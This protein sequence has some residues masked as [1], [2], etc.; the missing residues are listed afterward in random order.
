MKL[1][2]LRHGE[3]EGNITGIMQGN[4]ETEL[5]ETGI[6]QAKEVSAFFQDK[7]IDLAI[8]SPRNRTKLTAELAVPNVP[9]IYDQRLRSRDHG[10]FEGLRKDEID[11]YEYWNYKINKK[12]QKAESIEDLFQ[13]VGSLLKEIKETY[14]D[15]TILLVTHSG[16]CR[17]IYYNFHKIPEDGNLLEYQ[18]KNC[19]V[20]EYDY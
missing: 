3:T 7:K 10:E 4:M 17:V 16:I 18:S 11:S 20:D 13:R 9:K 1:Y 5:N 8:V 2:V 12:Y 19:S 15:K 6:L 14:P